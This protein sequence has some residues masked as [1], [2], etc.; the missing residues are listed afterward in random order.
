LQVK[1]FEEGW[2]LFSPL[3][4]LIQALSSSQVAFVT[5]D[6]NIADFIAQNA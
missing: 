5:R 4:L 1:F 2:F 6:E 3:C